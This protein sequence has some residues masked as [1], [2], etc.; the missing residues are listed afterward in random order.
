MYPFQPNQYGQSTP[1][2]QQNNVPTNNPKPH[3]NSYPFIQQQFVPQ[4]FSN[5]QVA[6]FAQNRNVYAS[7]IQTST[8]SNNLNRPAGMGLGKLESMGRVIKEDPDPVIHRTQEAPSSFHNQLANNIP[9][10]N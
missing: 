1:N 9:M 10:G 2:N 5:P 6:T 7:T 8:S 3:P 4:G